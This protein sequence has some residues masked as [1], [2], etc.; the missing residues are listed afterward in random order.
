MPGLSKEGR[1]GPEPRPPYLVR[2]IM[3]DGMGPRIFSIITK[4]SR[5]SWVCGRVGQSNQ[6]SVPALAPSE[7]KGQKFPPCPRR[8]KPTAVLAFLT[9]GSLGPGMRPTYSC[10]VRVGLL[11][12][13]R[14]GEPH[15]FIPAPFLT[16]QKVP[17]SMPSL[18]AVPLCL[19][20]S[21]LPSQASILKG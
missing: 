14:S 19:E 20:C 7:K 11:D 15:E 4:C 16:P 12:P 6:G 18:I 9:C 17:I 2:W 10:K 5:F 21:F 13:P 8:W 1:K 3:W